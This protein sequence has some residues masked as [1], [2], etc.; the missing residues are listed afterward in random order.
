MLLMGVEETHAHSRLDARLQG[1][2]RGLMNG[3]S[4]VPHRP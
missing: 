2:G 4:R 3:R 1:L